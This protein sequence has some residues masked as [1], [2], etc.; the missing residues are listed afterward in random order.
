MPSGPRFS[1]TNGLPS[2]APQ[3]LSELTKFTEAK[4]LACFPAGGMLRGIPGGE[5]LPGQTSS[6]NWMHE[7]CCEHDNWEQA[8][9]LLPA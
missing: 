9:Q 5:N 8:D 7:K 2:P 1:K 4:D 3:G 6:T